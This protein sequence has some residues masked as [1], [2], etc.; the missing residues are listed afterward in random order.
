MQSL[1]V[2][3]GGSPWVG[4]HSLPHALKE[5]L[6][7]HTFPVGGDGGSSRAPPA[8]ICRD[9]GGPEAS[10]L[11]SQCPKCYQLPLCSS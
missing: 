9:Q 11:R 10:E 7:S 2:G 8:C 3:W 4:L 5:I 6:Q 1:K